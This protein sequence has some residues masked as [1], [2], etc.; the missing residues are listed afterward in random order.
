M[1]KLP[2][3]LV[4]LLLL[5]LRLSFVG[6]GANA[7]GDEFRYWYS[8]QC[9]LDVSKGEF[10]SALAQL[11]RANARP[12]LVLANLPP[13]LVQSVVYQ[14]V[15]LDPR[16]P[17][18]LLVPQWWN[19]LVSVAQLLLFYRLVR[20]WLGLGAVEAAGLVLVYGLFASSN[21]YLRHLLPY[22]FVLLCWFYLLDRASGAKNAWALGGLAGLVYLT[23][24]GYWLLVPTLGVVWLHG[25]AGGR[26]AFAWTHVRRPL[27]FV[28]GLLTPVVFFE[29]LARLI[30]QSLLAE[31]IRA[32]DE[33]LNYLQYYDGG[34]RLL[35]DYLFTMEGGVGVLLGLLSVGFM[36]ERG[37]DCWRGQPLQP[38]DLVVL[39]LFLGFCVQALAGYGSGLKV[40]Y[41]RLFKMYLPFMTLAA[42]WCW[43]HGLKR[44]LGRFGGR[45]VPVL[46]SGLV[47][48]WTM[49]RF[50]HFYQLYHHLGYPRD[51]LYAM[52]LSCQPK[53]SQDYDIWVDQPPKD[54]LRRFNEYR[55]AGNYATIPP[56]WHAPNP[57]NEAHKKALFVN[58]TLLP[59]YLEG[60]FQPL[61]L[62]DSLIWQ[63]RTPHFMSWE[64]Y[65]FEENLSGKRTYFQGRTLMLGVAGPR[66]F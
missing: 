30:G 22:D 57:P 15:G 14:W 42:G 19:V 60:T 23:Y 55:P 16:S 48:A 17:D 2:I 21:F 18:A 65:W 47:L 52:G 64:G 38:V 7:F 44:Y 28:A 63:W 1:K 56:G 33:Y 20:R 59:C 66:G 12:C 5:V 32:G 13:V 8:A 58:F 34:L 39:V 10:A 26:L 49:V 37:R 50:G 6:K 46:A 62:P 3:V 54:G 25:Q 61:Q 29:A 53:G 35:A 4:C 41:G 43:F 24:P 27:L 40:F 31:S 45:V 11:F 51:A 36:V 9:L